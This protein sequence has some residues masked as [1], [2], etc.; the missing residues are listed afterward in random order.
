MSD[1]ESA[2]LE[3]WPPPLAVWIVTAVSVISV[4]LLVLVTVLR[5]EDSAKFSAQKSSSERTD[6]RN[7]IQAQFNDVRDHRDNLLGLIAAL[8]F[9][10]D[11][12]GARAIIPQ[13][14]MAIDAVNALP[15]FDHA[16]D[17][18]YTIAGISYPA[19]PTVK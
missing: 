8:A 14:N 9:S 1:R 7:E 6:C 18:G 12:A 13:L 3:R 5:F 19:C 10:G 11:G 16:V 4:A 2:R 17:H 15:D